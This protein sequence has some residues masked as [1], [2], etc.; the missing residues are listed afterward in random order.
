M[1][2]L[3]ETAI[4]NLSGAATMVV[5]DSSFSLELTTACLRGFGIRSDMR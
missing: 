3:R 4:V 2:G 1:D 5:D